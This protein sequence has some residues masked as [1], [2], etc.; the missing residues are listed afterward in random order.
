MKKLL[1]YGGIAVLALLGAGALLGFRA[2]DSAAQESPA[3]REQTSVYPPRLGGLGF[4]PGGFGRGIGFGRGGC[5]QDGLAA[6]ADALDMT[7]DELSTQLWGGR[8]LADLADRAGVDLEDLRQAVETACQDAVEQSIQDAVDSG[9]L[10][11]EQGD[12]LLQGL[13]LGFVGGRGHGFLPRFGW[14]R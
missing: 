1:T 7:A 6:A 5:G 4:G 11:Q 3:V 10:T 9:R 8:T 14:R 13:D 12:W 2:F